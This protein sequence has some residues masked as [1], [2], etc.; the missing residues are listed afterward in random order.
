MIQVAIVAELLEDYTQLLS[1][2]LHHMLQDA[3]FPRRVRLLILRNLPFSSSAS[4]LS[5][6]LRPPPPR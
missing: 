6:S 3:P 5:S 2:A 4:S 1:R